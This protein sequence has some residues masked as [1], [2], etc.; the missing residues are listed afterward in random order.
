M[1][2][3]NMH[4]GNVHIIELRIMKIHFQSSAKRKVAT[5]TIGTRLGITPAAD[6]TFIC[7]WAHFQS[8]FSIISTSSHTKTARRLIQTT[9]VRFEYCNWIDPFRHD[10]YNSDVCRQK[11]FSISDSLI[12][13]RVFDTITVIT[14]FVCITSCSL[15]LLWFPA[16]G[17]VPYVF[18]VLRHFTAQHTST[19]VWHPREAFNTERWLAGA[20]EVEQVTKR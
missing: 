12:D 20:I 13:L 2:V 19:T 15:R 1:R 16:E 8:R 7:I 5:G 18:R 10:F 9:W 4:A 3:M 14:I 17:F 6:I 11:L